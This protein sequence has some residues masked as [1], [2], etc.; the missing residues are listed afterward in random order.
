MVSTF[1]TFLYRKKSYIESWLAC[2]QVHLR[3]DIQGDDGHYANIHRLTKWAD[4]P[5]VW[6]HFGPKPLRTNRTTALFS[7]IMDIIDA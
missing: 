6:F 5:P 1:V 7:V 2:A 3:W 4:S